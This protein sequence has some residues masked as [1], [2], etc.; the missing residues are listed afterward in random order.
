MGAFRRFLDRLTET[1]E[2]RLATEIRDW[3]A[4]VPGTTRI[5][6]IPLR[7]KVRIAGMIRRLTVFP[8]KDNESLE[9]VVA[10]GSGEL[11][12]RFMGRRA[13]SG[14]GLGTKVVLEGV[15]AEQRGVYQ[16]MNPRLEFTA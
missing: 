2:A 3:A 9:A 8:M 15:V 7:Q 4:S 10:D 12:V 13:I 6:E 5:A 16:M 14:L 11:V 1:D